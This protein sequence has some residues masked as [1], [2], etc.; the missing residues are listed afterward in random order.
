M[1]FNNTTPIQLFYCEGDALSSSNP[2]V[3]VFS[4]R[5]PT[6]YDFDF[7]IQKRWFNYM[8]TREWMLL[9]TPLVN[10]QTTATWV[11]LN[12]SGS[13]NLSIPVPLGTS[14][15]TPSNTGVL[16]FTSSDASI[17][18]TGSLNTI[19][20]QNM[21]AINSQTL[22]GD[23]GIAITPSGGTIGLQGLVVANSTNAKAVFIAEGSAHV[24]QVEV[25]LSAAIASTNIAKVGLSAFN[26]SQFVV[27]GNGFVS[28]IGGS[29]A[30]TLGIVPDIHT[31]PGT[32]PVV[33]NVSGNIIMTGSLVAAGTHP[34]RIDSLMTNTIEVEVQTAQAIASTNASNVGLSAF[35]SSQFTVDGNGF[36]SLSTSGGSG[37]IVQEIRTST[38]VSTSTGQILLGRGNTPT[39]S[40]TTLLISLSLTPKNAS[41]VLKFT[42][43]STYSSTAGVGF[44]VFS[45]NTLLGSYN[46]YPAPNTIFQNNL[47]SFNLYSVAG[48]TSPTTYAIY[49]V[50]N[51]SSASATAQTLLDGI[52]FN[53]AVWNG[54]E[55]TQFVVTEVLP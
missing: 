12:S 16:T 23:D 34:V 43:N 54:S 32:S 44:F 42:F 9:A 48:T 10:N 35:N 40:N 52:G 1:T 38:N 27:D 14:P 55:L 28:L 2:F 33:P 31:N 11:M 41:N 46:A 4:N 37:S 6:I 3:T 8:L 25:Q 18:I 21:S 39:T 29:S 26:A 51:T 30:P 19:N 17:A 50:N 20:F 15:V 22:T 13:L 53:T 45:G 36:V 49:W 47:V 7:P 5:D 24:E